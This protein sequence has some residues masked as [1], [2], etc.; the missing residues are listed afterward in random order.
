[1]INNIFFLPE[2]LDDVQSAKEWYEL[3]RDGLG[4]EFQL[5]LEACVQSIKNNPERYPKVLNQIRKGSIKRFPYYVIYLTETHKV[6]VLAVLHVKRS[7]D[8]LFS[9]LKEIGLGEA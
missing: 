6:V 1:M 5:S 9:R 2:A 3:Q 7:P 8:S 4:D